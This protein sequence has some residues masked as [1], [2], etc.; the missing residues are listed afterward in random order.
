ML[1]I[2]KLAVFQSVRK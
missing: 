1:L 2:V